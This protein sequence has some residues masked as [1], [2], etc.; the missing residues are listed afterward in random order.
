MPAY[1]FSKKRIESPPAVPWTLITFKTFALLQNSTVFFELIFHNNSSL[2]YLLL[3][4]SNPQE[5]AT[6]MYVPICQRG[7][8]NAD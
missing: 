3:M 4:L 1:T 2:S 8:M 7:H 6:Y 5:N